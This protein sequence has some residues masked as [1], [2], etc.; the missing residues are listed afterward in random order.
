M[1]PINGFVAALALLYT[2]V[3]S[4][5]AP[6]LS[7]DRLQPADQNTRLTVK[8]LVQGLEHPWSMAWLPNGDMLITERAGRLRRL[9]ADHQTL[10]GA[11]AGLPSDMVVQGQGGLLDV[12]VH[13]N[14]KTNGWIYLSYVAQSKAAPYARGTALIRARLTPN[15]LSDVR[16]LF[17]MST[18]SSTSRHFGG[19]MALDAAGHIYLGL[20]DR[21]QRELVQG[22]QAGHLGAVVRL[23]DDG[24]IPSDNPMAA[25][26]PVQ[27]ALY[28]RGH[29]NIQG[30]AFQPSTGLLW[31]HEHG[32]QG[33]DEVNQLQVGANYGWPLVTHGVNYGSGTAIG[34]GTSMPNMVSPVHVWVPSIAPS[35]MAFYQGS[36]FASWQGNLLVGALRGQALVRLVLQQQRVVAEHRL[37]QGQVGRIRDVRV[38][39]DGLIYLLT[40]RANGTLLQ[41]APA[42]P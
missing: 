5:A 28:T 10:S 8:T 33:G 42:T 36:R 25:G 21:G 30:L 35:G 40:D 7:A 31:A 13:P 3:A 41:I 15:G 39:P 23:R 4:A 14:H 22:Q 1:R 20:G 18:Q 9:S 6:T 32:P 38:G 27:S 29:R 24:S 34:Q 17:E 12:A 2:G 19:R 26:G 16:K 37:L 11:L